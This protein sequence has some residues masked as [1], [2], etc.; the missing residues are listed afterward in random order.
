MQGSILSDAHA[1][2]YGFILGDDGVQYSFAL[3][4]WR[5]HQTIPSVGMKNDFDLS[6]SHAAVIYPVL[7]STP[8]FAHAAPAQYPQ[9]TSVNPSVSQVTS[10]VASSRP[11]WTALWNSLSET[12]RIAACIVAVTGALQVLSFVF[13]AVQV[14]ILISDHL[15]IQV[16]IDDRLLYVVLGDR[17]LIV[18]A[19]L[20]PHISLHHLV[21]YNSLELTQP[22]VELLTIESNPE[23]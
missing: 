8:P 18:E 22:E 19:G 7:G 23:H 16:D 4:D 17:L 3:T 6:G 15:D 21:N 14:A 13:V 11:N 2:N 1:S 20:P 9:T 10:A 12:Y 5:D